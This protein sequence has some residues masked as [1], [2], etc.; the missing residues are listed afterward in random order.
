MVSH[1]GFRNRIS[2]FV[3]WAW[4]YFTWDRADRLIVELPGP[5]PLRS[6]S[7]DT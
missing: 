1:T 3:S 7:E 2:V 6:A 4:N 5:E